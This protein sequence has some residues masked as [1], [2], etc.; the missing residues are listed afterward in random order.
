MAEM[1]IYHTQKVEDFAELAKEHLDGE[2]EFYEQVS[3]HLN[4]L[5]PPSHRSF[6]LSCDYAPQV[7]LRLR[8]ARRTFDP[9]T[10]PQLASDGPRKPSIYERDLEQ[11]CLNPEPLPQPCPHVFDAMPMRPVSLAIQEGVGL[12]L[13]TAANAVSGRSSVFGRFW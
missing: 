9:P 6:L 13:G 1:D 4:T 11:P 7:L 2:I 8:T 10:Y 3:T 12:L 5:R